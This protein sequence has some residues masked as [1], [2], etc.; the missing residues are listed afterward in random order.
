M[1]HFFFFFLIYEILCIQ[2]KTLKQEQSIPLVIQTEM[3]IIGKVVE[4]DNILFSSVSYS[5]PCVPERFVSYIKDQC[6]DSCPALGTP[7]LLCFI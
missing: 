2:T 5:F 4:Y 1:E 3:E 7:V 6:H